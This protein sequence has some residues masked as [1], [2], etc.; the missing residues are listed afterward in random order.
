MTD[1]GNFGDA[2]NIRL[3]ELKVLNLGF[4]YNCINPTLAVLYED[5]KE[6]RHVKTYEVRLRSKVRI[7]FVFLA[8]DTYSSDMCSLQFLCYF[9]YVFVGKKY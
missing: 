5:T 3:D 7:F 4:L 9:G 6:Q 8:S 1:A 2:F